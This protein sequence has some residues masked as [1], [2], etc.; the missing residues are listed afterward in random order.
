MPAMAIAGMTIQRLRMVFLITSSLIENPI[1]KG[2]L[3][4]ADTSRPAAKAARISRNPGCF[5]TSR[6]FTVPDAKPRLRR[7]Q[8]F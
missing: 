6:A 5:E 4:R 3:T 1:Y 8:I 7:R 2:K